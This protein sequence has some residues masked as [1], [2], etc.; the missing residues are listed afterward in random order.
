ME[1]FPDLLCPVHR[2]SLG[3]QRVRAPGPRA[4]WTLGGR[5]EMHYLRQSMH[6]GIG[7]AGAC[8]DY[9]VT[10]NLGQNAIER[11]LHSAGLRLSLPAT[12]GTAVV[13]Q[14]KDYSQDTLR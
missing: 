1:F 11:I 8:R 7:A 13:F 6:A 4:E 9:P 3:Q 12:E 2:H 10:G 14:A 5:I